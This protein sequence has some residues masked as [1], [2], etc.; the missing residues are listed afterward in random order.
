MVVAVLSGASV[1]SANPLNVVASSVNPGG[2]PWRSQSTGRA[3]RGH[4]ASGMHLEEGK[5]IRFVA[6]YRPRD[7]HWGTVE[8]VSVIQRAARKVSLAHGTGRMAV[9]ELSAK[10]GGRVDGHA[11]H[12][13]GRDVD[14]GFYL[15]DEKDKTLVW[16]EFVYLKKDGTRSLAGGAKQARFD[17]AR[18][19]TLVESLVSDAE[20]PVQYIFVAP[21]IERLLLNYAR[22]I[23]ASP[24]LIDR[25]SQMMMPPGSGRPHT[26]HFHVRIYCPGDDKPVCKDVGAVWSWSA[27][28]RARSQRLAKL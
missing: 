18:N 23:D 5:H 3:T 21:S 11:S 2:A 1:V 6:K 9:G 22:S 13:S 17:F 4:L 28:M 19:W 26:D 8:L 25:A 27:P 10:Y 24:E 16:P 15:L 12:Q 20:A 14:I 7:R